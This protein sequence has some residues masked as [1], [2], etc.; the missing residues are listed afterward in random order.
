MVLVVGWVD[1]VVSRESGASSELLV[2]LERR[3]NSE[4]G[5][6]IYASG[7]R[8]RERESVVGKLGPIVC[9]KRSK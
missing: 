4:S 8:E 2:S 9:R 1:S 6:F 7:E 3:V 5:W